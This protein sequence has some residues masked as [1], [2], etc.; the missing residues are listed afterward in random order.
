MVLIRLGVERADLP[1][2]ERVVKGG[3]DLVGR[4]AQPR[5]SRA[6]D[7]QVHAYA[8][9][10]LIGCNVTH[11]R[12][13][14][15]LGYKPVGPQVKFILVGVFERVL[16]L[17]AADAIIDSQVLHGLQVEVDTSDLVGTLLQPCKNVP[18]TTMPLRAGLQVDL[19][20][21]AVQGAVCAIR[22]NE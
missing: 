3:V 2:T 5:R 10:L 16:V 21:A 1:L 4:D 17:R 22:P 15:Q 14:A 12:D 8:V 13:S 20:T 7:V 19:N 11:L 9:G 6:I 18:G